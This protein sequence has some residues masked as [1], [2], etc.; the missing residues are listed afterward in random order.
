MFA[1]MLGAMLQ[2]LFFNGITEYAAFA[3]I[4]GLALVVAVGTSL[5]TRPVDEE[6]LQQFYVTTRPF[7]FWKRSRQRLGSDA[8]KSIRIEHRRDAGSTVVA[9]GWQ[10]TLFLTMMFVVL[11][12]WET[13][14]VL[15]ALLAIFSTLLYRLWYRHLPPRTPDDAPTQQSLRREPAAVSSPA[16]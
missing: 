6:V 2:R 4:G 15:L 14:A 16:G 3:S 10:L 1:G 9:V 13:L 11:K 7:G 5:L 8:V 12:V